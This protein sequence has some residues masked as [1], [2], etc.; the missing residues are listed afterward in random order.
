MKGLTIGPV[1]GTVKLIPLPPG[2][3]RDAATG[4]KLKHGERVQLGEDQ[5]SSCWLMYDNSSLAAR[6]SKAKGGKGKLGVITHHPPCRTV[7]K[8]AKEFVFVAF[9]HG[10]KKRRGARVLRAPFVATK[11]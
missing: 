10:N 9:P 4:H 3:P 5:D 8:L 6:I 11:K 7:K 2:L 1:K